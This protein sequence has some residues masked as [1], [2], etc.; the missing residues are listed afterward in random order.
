[1]KLQEITD[2]LEDNFPLSLQESYDNSGL[3]V[4][5]KSMELKSALICLDSTEEVVDEAIRKGANLIISH[6][7][8]IF[9]GIKSLTGETYIER[10][11]IR[12]I[13]NNIA[14]YAIHTN[15]DNHKQ[16]VNA[17]IAK[18]IGLTQCRILRPKKGVLCK[19]V[20]YLPKEA[21]EPLDKALFEKG[22]G[23]IGNYSECHF[24]TEGIGTFMPNK[25]AKPVIG[26][27]DIRSSISEYRVEYLVTYSKLQAVLAAL[28][29]SH[30]YE[31]IPY[32]IL[33]IDNE[34]QDE[35]AGMIGELDNAMSEKDFLQEL[36][37]IFN[38]GI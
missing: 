10:I 35:G 13:Q 24:R 1:M 2:Y 22:A 3:L 11:V 34:N 28:Q 9:S 26:E 32:E 17:E 27:A 4:G 33:P 25:M 23:R 19:L 16:G 6:H 5:N 7:P 30:P 31:E 36:K 38:C 8:I 18:R 29:T 37:T 15:L 14:L 21:L 20:V 12:C